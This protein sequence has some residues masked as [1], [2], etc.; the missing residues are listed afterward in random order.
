MTLSAAHLDTRLVVDEKGRARL[1]TDTSLSVAPSGD[2]G[3]CI[4]SVRAMRQDDGTLAATWWSVRNDSSAVLLAAVSAD[5]G[6]TW[7]PPLRVDTADVSVAGC[8]RP[9]PAI[10]ASA[11]F[12][13]IAYSMR[14]RG[15]A[16]V[17]YAHSMTRGKSYEPAI[18][19]VYGDRLT[20]TAIAADRGTVA[21][22][23][24]DPNGATPQIGLAISRDWGHIFDER[25]RGSTGVGAATFPEVAVA[26]RQI[27]VSWMQGSSADDSNATATR[28]VRVGRLR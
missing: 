25:M 6:R 4:G 8:S 11:G 7:G 24:E 28:I 26:N 12:L 17:F 2:P 23:Y 5:A 22:A 27:A 18:T 21:V 1:I 13:H 15:G 10:S 9:A 20:R 3:M 19:I 16:G 14:D